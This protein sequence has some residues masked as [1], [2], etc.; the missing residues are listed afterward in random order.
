MVDVRALVLG[1]SA[2]AG[3]LVAL[4][5]PTAPAVLAVGLG[6][7]AVVVA[8]VRGR[9]AIGWLGP[10]VALAAVAGVAVLQQAL[11]A[12]SPV[13]DLA[14]EHA[15]VS[16][17]LTITS[18]VRVVAGGF[19][20]Q[21][22]VRARIT[23][24]QGR[25]ESWRTRVPVVVLADVDWPA[26]PLGTVV[27]QRLR[28]APATGDAVAL[29]RPVGGAPVLVSG[30]GPAW[31]AA[32]AVRRSVR[33][34]VSGRQPDAAAL[35][36][37]LVVGDDSALD[38]ALADDF[39]DTGLTHLLAVSGTNLTL[40]V[41]FLVIAGRWAGVSGRGTWLLA[42]AGIVGFVLVARD[43]PSVVRAA[44]MGTTAL[45]GMGSNGLSRGTRCLGIAVLLL[46]LAQP[47]LALTAGFALSVLATAGILLLAPVWRDSLAR[48]LPRWVAEAVAVPLAAQVA[49]TPVV[50]AISGD[51]SL[52]AVAANLLAA[53]AVAPATVL[54]LGGGLLGLAWPALGSV[55]AAPGAWSAGWI[56][57]VARWAA[58][59][60]TPSIEWG[61]GPLA[62]A[63]LTALCV[64]AVVVA[65]RV[66]R[67]RGTAIGCCALVV[68][69][70]L[71]RVP[72]P[73][74]PPK[75][76]VLVMCDVG[77][78]DALVVNAGPRAAVV[79][80]AGPDPALADRC[81]D[82]LGITRV[83]LV[84]LTHFH[85]DHVDGLPGVLDGRVVGAVES[86]W[87]AR[88]ASGVDAVRR[89]LTGLPAV[90]PWGSTREVGRA[91]IQPVWPPPQRPGTVEDDTGANDHSVVLLVDVEGVRLLLTGDVE[92]PGQG[93]LR[94]T[95]AGLHVDV[96][97]VPHHGSRHQDLPWLTGLG[98]RVALVSVG[99]DN[100]YGH[101][102]SPVLLALE[103]TGA[104]VWRTDRSG[105]VAVV[106]DGGAVAVAARG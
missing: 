46:L 56:I 13:A 105:D 90:S 2:W 68:V 61:S 78:G 51:V 67:H 43:E 32:A 54:G 28:L 45:V 48:W 52:V 24:V 55:V 6:A 30:P 21:Q 40:V 16:A 99:E 9:V 74:W 84:V 1:A 75:G 8:V 81:L 49:C 18:D 97:K 104:Q 15:V 89:A 98:A 69:A 71:V 96:V 29:A 26:P 60:P 38:S 93:A 10:V 11:L 19:T 103:A 39:R 57:T 70:I 58:A 73:G 12:T 100:D 34:V 23:G 76:W 65:P 3:A 72:S 79:V 14:E 85:A 86:T 88:P 31:D 80:D 47:R 5:L 17:R 35:V 106:V 59:L 7:L 95:L 36:P 22:V 20:D 82:A 4:L 50:A 87:L 37:A 62:L 27:V 64:A 92:P 42:G 101:P 94:R 91:R 102:S 66:L 33:D 41:G 77:Q 53:P 83:P 63:V 25:G 44:A